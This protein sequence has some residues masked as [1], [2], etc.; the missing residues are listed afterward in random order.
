MGLMSRWAEGAFIWCRLCAGPSTSSATSQYGPEPSGS[1]SIFWWGR[2]IQ[3]GDLDRQV[4][5]IRG[6]V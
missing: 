6:P 4:G 5:L 2:Q 3:G 1:I